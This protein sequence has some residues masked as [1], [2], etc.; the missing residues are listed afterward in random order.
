MAALL[1]ST[2]DEDVVVMDYGT[3]KEAAVV[4]ADYQR[5]I[6]G[7]GMGDCPVSKCRELTGLLQGA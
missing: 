5:L 3:L 6:V 7:V 4:D 2:M 1:V